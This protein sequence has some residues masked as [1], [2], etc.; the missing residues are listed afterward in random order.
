MFGIRKP[1]HDVPELAERPLYLKCTVHD[2]ISF[3]KG[4]ERLIYGRRTKISVKPMRKL[5]FLCPAGSTD[6]HFR[7]LILS[8]TVS[9]GDVVLALE[10]H[11]AYKGF[12]PIGPLRP[13][14]KYG[15]KL[16]EFSL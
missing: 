6:T 3:Q 13:K 12:T 14:N 11:A 4:A 10:L 7:K 8:Y 16:D 5:D 2:K 9:L 1:T 15:R